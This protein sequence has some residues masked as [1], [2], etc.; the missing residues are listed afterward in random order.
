MKR[1]IIYILLIISAEQVIAQDTIRS[2]D[3][4][5]VTIKAKNENFMEQIPSGDKLNLRQLQTINTQ[6]V[7]D[8]AKFLGGVLV[9]D[10]GGLGGVKTI[11]V[12]GLSAN[13]TSVLY[14]GVSLFDNQSGQ[15]D[16]SKYSLSSINSLSL[17]NA[18]FTN[19]LPTAT[20]LASAS[21]V[22]IETK[23][24]KF[25]EKSFFGDMSLSYGS[26]N[27]VSGNLFLA[28][29]L[30]NRDVVTF[31]CDVLNTDGRYDYKIYY[32]E[33]QKL[34]TKTEKREN[35]DVFSTHGEMNW[36]HTFSVRN[37]LKLKAFYYY[38]N[39]GLPS[40]V[41]LYYQN[42]KQRLWNKN[43]FSQSEF[44]SQISEKIKYK[45]S[46]KF[47]W[48]YTHYI[49]PH[50][51]GYA[52]GLDD[53]YTQKTIYMNNVVS[54]QDGE[55]VCVVL[56]NDITCNSL[57]YTILETIPKRFSMLTAAVVN[58]RKNDFTITANLLHS[59]YHDWFKEDQKTKNY[60][61]PFLNL[62]YTKGVWTMSLF[63][64][65][66]FRMPTFNELYYRRM[67]NTDLKPEM[68]NQ[69]S[70]ANIFDFSNSRYS[71][72]FEGDIYYNNVRN[73]IV[74]IAQNQFLW[75]MLNYGKVDIYGVD[76]KVS[77]DYFISQNWHIDTKINYSY[78]KALD[79][80]KNSYTY[81]QNIPYMPENV[82]NIILGIDYKW[83]RLGYTCLLVDK[84]WSLQ[85][86]I[87]QN[88]LKA[89]ADHS[90]NISYTKETSR[91][92]IKKYFIMLSLNN[93]FDY[94]YE[95]IRSYPMMGRN[96]SLKVQLYF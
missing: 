15:I 66:I 59:L 42:S 56:T 2:V 79:T 67:G 24:P 39:R 34:S 91:S 40:N 92:V 36:Y 23:K 13:H 31:M 41:T 57:D 74:A 5:T 72:L 82:A 8:A 12:R 38:S 61:S 11:S 77:F 10:Y 17:A 50:Y 87:P 73:K 44:T 71:L 75:T 27:L 70:M 76:L 32:G 94:Q 49:D 20:S 89:Y 62:K 7:G 55:G 45:N 69:Y 28:S 35:N 68:T 58:Y 54:Y 6:N 60:F 48:N 9:K 93:I 14:D 19:F 16:L 84:R 86:N 90:V 88:L 95:I 64:K 25:R 43:F 46:L 65:N 85:E 47:D 37:N 80:D 21:S 26:F 83:W 30:S 78:Q 81:K 63:Y 18:G 52:N 4:D 3:L 22:D 51:L 53:N 33:N 1:I 96:Y 29:K